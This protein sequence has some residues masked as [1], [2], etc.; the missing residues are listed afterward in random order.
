VRRQ[1][2]ATT[3]LW[4]LMNAR[5]G[6][7]TSKAASHFACRRTPKRDGVFGAAVPKRSTYQALFTL[8]LLVFAGAPA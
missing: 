2:A 3:A 1:S 7:M 6:S 8:D 5:L 4:Q